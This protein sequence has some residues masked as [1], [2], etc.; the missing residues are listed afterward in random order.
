VAPC[1]CGSIACD[2]GGGDGTIWIAVSEGRGGGGRQHVR[3]V[4]P[5]VNEGGGGDTMWVAVSEGRGGGGT[6]W[7]AVSEGGVGGGAAPC[8]CG[9]TAGAPAPRTAPPPRCIARLPARPPR[10]PA[11]HPSPP[12]SMTPTPKPPCRSPRASGLPPV[13]ACRSLYPH[14]CIYAR[15]YLHLRVR[16]RLDSSLHPPLPSTRPFCTCI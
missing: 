13:P 7:V 15:R 6:M 11:P 12:P 2:E 1:A 16:L 10:H 9:S 3:A 4:V 14:V 5:Q 8:A